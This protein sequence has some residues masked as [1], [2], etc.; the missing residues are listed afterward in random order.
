VNVGE[1]TTLGDCNVAEEL[2]QLFIVADG[3]LEV[4]RDNTSLLVVSSSIASKFEDFGSKILEN[5]SEID[6]ST[7]TDTLGVVALSQETVDTADG[8]CE[9]SF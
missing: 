5:G 6:R 1:D 2:V 7:S 8:E 3:E 9:T 4:T